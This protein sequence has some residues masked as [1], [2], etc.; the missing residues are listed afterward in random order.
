MATSTHNARIELAIADLKSQ[1]VPKY[2]ATARKYA[3]EPSTLRRRFQH[4]TTSKEAANSLYRQ[5]LTFAQEEVLI[6]EINDLTE[7]AIPPTSQMVRNLAEE[8]IQRPVGKNWTGD[9]LKRYKD[10]LRSQYL[11][12]IDNNRA[13]SEYVPSFE[14]FYDL[15]ISLIPS[16]TSN[17]LKNL[18]TLLCTS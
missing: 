4:I 8:I 5:R 17:S 10:R 18:L 3:L 9:F 11:M 13:K 16:F 7:R 2:A 12:N 15:V 1:E 6:G 14:H